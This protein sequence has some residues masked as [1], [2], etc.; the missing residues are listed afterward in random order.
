MIEN[1]D[2]I[3]P[4]LLEVTPVSGAFQIGET[5]SGTITD[6]EGGT[7]IE[8]VR[9]RLASPNHKDGPFNQPTIL[10]NN[11]PYEANV[12][13]SSSYSETT[14]VL[15]IDTKSLSQ[16]SDPNFFGRVIPGQRLVGET[17]G[18][19]AVVDQIRLITDDVGAVI[20]CYHIEEGQ[21]INGTNTALISSLRSNDPV[22]PGVNSVSYTHLRAHET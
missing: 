8:S 5:V 7:D 13:L 2:N 14:T 1:R 9:F 22:T 18:A 16:K 3:T 6:P 20:G 10:F 12:G 15:N 21:F 19:E 17:S 11:N 4:K